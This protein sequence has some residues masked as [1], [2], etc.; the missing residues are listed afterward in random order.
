[1]SAVEVE[2]AFSVAGISCNLGERDDYYWFVDESTWVDW[3]LEAHASAPNY[4][5]ITATQRGFDCDKFARHL[6]DHVAVKYLANG[7]FEV[8]G[9]ASFGGHAWNVI[10]TPSGLF[11]VEPQNGDIW[12]A[13]T[14]P[15]YKIKTIYHADASIQM[16]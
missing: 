10:L 1:M 2:S 15:G 3:I 7:C 14:N 4:Q 8:W 12:I 16:K 6:C 5:P 13:G 11:E 9:E